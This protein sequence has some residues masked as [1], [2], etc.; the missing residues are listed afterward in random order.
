MYA[1][2]QRRKDFLDR[3]R[4]F[5]K[6]IFNRLTT[7]LTNWGRGPFTLLRHQG[8]RSGKPYQ[9]PV[10]ATNIDNMVIIPL[11][12]G[13]HV[14]W[15]QNILAADECELIRN[16]RRTLGKSPEVITAEEASAHLPENRRDLFER[17]EVKK[18]LRLTV[19]E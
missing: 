6:H 13:E 7:R 17:F 10:L 12:Y 9:T 3:V 16:D 18:F 14:D 4:I 15:L 5:N 19:A 11:S 8:R 2:E 1:R